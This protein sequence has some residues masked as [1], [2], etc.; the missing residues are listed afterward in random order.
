MEKLPEEIELNENGDLEKENFRDQFA[1][2]EKIRFG[3]SSFDAW[4]IHPSGEE[5]EVPVLFVSG[6]GLTPRTYEEG[7]YEYVKAGRRV[8]AF[9][10]PA[11]EAKSDQ[12]RTDDYPPAQV[13]HANAILTLIEA[14]NLNKVD[15]IAHSEGCINVA[16]AAEMAPDLFRHFVLVAPPDLTEKESRLNII[17]QSSRNSRGLRKELDAVSKKIAGD[18]A[19]REEKE[20]YVKEEERIPWS[21]ATFYVTS[22]QKGGMG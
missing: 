20:Q 11:E 1:H 19:T 21:R 7:I 18:L 14:K 5:K 10:S 12:V 16:I 13:H 2:P 9:S 6:W 4:D 8:L 17:K 22:R 15:I 3:E